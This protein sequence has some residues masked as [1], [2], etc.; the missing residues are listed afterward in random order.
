MRW[1][2]WDPTTHIIRWCGMIACWENSIITIFSGPSLYSYRGFIKLNLCITW[3]S[4]RFDLIIRRVYIY[5]FY[6]PLTL[7]HLPMIRH[8][9]TDLLL[10]PKMA[11]NTIPLPPIDHPLTHTPPCHAIRPSSMLRHCCQWRGSTPAAVA[12][13]LPKQVRQRA[14]RSHIRVF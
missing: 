7:R 13:V 6:W 9:H 10:W 11:A 3:A 5:L 2:C 14:Q 12:D 4:T 1:L 8:H